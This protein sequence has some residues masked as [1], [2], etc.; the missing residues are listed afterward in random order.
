MDIDQLTECA[1]IEWWNFNVK[2]LGKNSSKYATNS[3]GM[4]CEQ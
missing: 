2:Y 1:E 4:L 3:D